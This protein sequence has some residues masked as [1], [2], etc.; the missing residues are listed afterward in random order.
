MTVA[1]DL[2][3]L[4]YDM[5]R[6]LYSPTCLHTL[7]DFGCGVIRGTYAA[8]GTVGGGST[9]S[10]INF[11]GALAAT[12][13]GSIVFPS[14]VNANVRATVK[15]VA[16][17][18]SL[19][20][21]YPLPSP[22]RRATPSRSYAA[23]TTRARPVSRSSTISPISAASR[24]CRRRRSLTS[25]GGTRMAN[26]EVV[27]PLAT[28]H[29]PLAER[30][31][32]TAV[33]AS[34]RAWLGTP[35]HHMAD[36]QGV[37]FDCA[38][39][40]VRVF[41]DLG[42]VEPFDPR[43]Y[44]K[45]WQLHRDEERYLGFLLARAHEVASPLP[46]DVML[47]ESAAVS[48]TAESSRRPSRWRSCTPSLPR[49][50]VLEEEIA[51]NVEVAARLPQ[52]RFA[53]YWRPERV[54][55][56]R[57]SKAAT[58][59]DYTGL[60]LQTSVNTLP[61][62]IVWGQTKAAANIVWYQNFQTHGGGSGGKGGF[63]GGGGASGYTYTADLI[64]ALCEGPISGIGVIWRDQ[65]TYT[66]AELGL[67]L[68]NGTTPQTVWGYLASAYPIRGACLSRHMLR[69]RGEL[70][71]RRCSRHRQS[72]F[73]DHWRSRRHGRQRNRR[74]SRAGRQRLPDQPAIRRR[75]LRRQHQC[76]DAVRLGR[77]RLAADLLRARSALHSA[78]LW[79]IRNRDRAFCRAGC[80]SSIAPRSGAAANSNSFPMATL[81][82]PPAMSF[83]PFNSPV[84]TP[85]QASSGVTPPPSITVCAPAEFAAD[86]GVTYAFT[87]APL[88][89]IG[90]FAPSTAGA[91]GLSPQGTYLFA[92]GDE[93]QVVSISYT[94]ASPTSYVPNLTPIYD[95]TDLDFVDEKGNKDPVQ[96]AR[97]DPFS[98]PTIQRVEC[99]SR[100]T[101]TAPRPSRRAINR[102]S[103][104][105]V[106]ASAPRSRRMKSATK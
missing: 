50:C 57:N 24:S 48:A 78:R 42:L 54:S 31:A 68:F 15:S 66:L 90:S 41:C 8:S 34:A 2:V 11:A 17:G 95:L 58:T 20:L 76:D 94:Y 28:R 59:P 82:S 104:F 61:I 102:R 88:T 79:W 25:N 65:S 36:V 29:S 40:L 18:A 89:Y 73:R 49:E 93:S 85:A 45:D 63:F 103:S 10:L 91:Y 5:P 74:R 30:E 21:M 96:A 55:W 47:F 67:T 32:R 6:N 101:N 37:G 106:L 9:A 4:D 70:S 19:A 35:Y 60:Q 62:P 14:G 12:A 71:A 13:Q 92:S 53:S 83:G 23:A 99:L 51:R 97:L 43:P 81:R 1:C 105:M 77:R 33:V 72:Q 75:L 44:V 100:T 86:G 87:G 3:M 80:R 26:G 16:V 98:L 69:L 52:A 46:G 38:M 56:F 7:Y 84:P 64:I 22:A 39:M 27:A